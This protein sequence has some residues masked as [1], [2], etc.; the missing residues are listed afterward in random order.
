MG[1]LCIEQLPV[2]A[3]GVPYAGGFLFGPL[4]SGPR[5]A[6][7]AAYLPLRAAVFRQMSLAVLAAAD[8]VFHN[9]LHQRKWRPHV[10]QPDISTLD[11][12]DLTQLRD[13]VN[14]RI[15]ELRDTGIVQL[16]A[17]IAEKAE[18]LG[19]ELKDLIPKKTRRRRS[20]DNSA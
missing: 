9:S 10:N 14:E 4:H 7:A 13:T 15:K 18:L 8:D 12:G 19:V 11:L 20:K 1:S 6:I 17:A 3:A 5:S 2:L 16:R